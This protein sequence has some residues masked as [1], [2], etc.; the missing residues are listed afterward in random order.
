MIRVELIDGFAYLIRN[1]ETF[2]PAYNWHIEEIE[3]IGNSFQNPK[4]L[5]GVY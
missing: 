2:C 3:I 1:N 5:D 4:L